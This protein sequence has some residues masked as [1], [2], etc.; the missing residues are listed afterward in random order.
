MHSASTEAAAPCVRALQV[1]RAFPN[2]MGAWLE[3]FAPGPTA[4]VAPPCYLGYVRS[5][6]NAIR[7]RPRAHYARILAE[8]TR[9]ANPEASHFV[10]RAM[11]YIFASV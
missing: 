11:L 1:G 9:C 4:T 7:R 3:E 10:E 8:L 6:A 5:T 2:T